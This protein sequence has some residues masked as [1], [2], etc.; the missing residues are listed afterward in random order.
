MKKYDT[1]II[2]CRIVYIYASNRNIIFHNIFSNLRD[3]MNNTVL[4]DKVK[5]ITNKRH[6]TKAWQKV[7]MVLSAITVFCTT[8]ALILPA[9]TMVDDDVALCGYVAHK[10]EESCYDEQGELICGLEEHEHDMGCLVTQGEKDKTVYFCAYDYEHTHTAACYSGDK[11]ICTMHE[12]THDDDCLKKT[13]MANATIKS[14]S[15]NDNAVAIVS[16]NLPVGAEAEI[17]VV[18][19]SRGELATY[20]GDKAAHVKQFAAY[21][22]KITLDGE[23]WQPDESVAVT[24][25][26]PDVNTDSGKVEAA[27]VDGNTNAISEVETEV[28]AKGDVQFEADGFSVYIIYTVDFEYNEAKY[29]IEGEGDILLSELFEKLKIENDVADV[30]SVDF[31]NDELL[32]IEDLGNDWRIVSLAPFDTEEKLT[33]TFKSGETLVIKVTDA[34]IA[35]NAGYWKKVTSIDDTNSSYIIV[36][37]DAAATDK[38]AFTR[39]NTGYSSTQVTINAVTGQTDYYTINTNVTDQM[40]FKFGK[41]IGTSGTTTVSTMN[42]NTP[43]YLTMTANNTA[44][45]T[46]STELTVKYNDTATSTYLANLWTFMNG[47][48]YYLNWANSAFTR[49]NSTTNYFS[50]RGMNL[51]KYYPG[52]TKDSGNFTVPVYTIPVDSNGRATGNATYQESLTVNNNNTSTTLANLFNNYDVDGTYY[53]AYY[54]TEYAAATSNVVSVTRSGNSNN[55]GANRRVRVTTSGGTTTDYNNDNNAIFLMY[56]TSGGGSTTSYWEPATEIKSGD[57]YMITYNGY[58]LGASSTA[59]GA[60]SAAAN[61]KRVDG[62]TDHYTTELGEAYQWTF[63]G[64]GN[65]YTIQNNETAT[66]YLKVNN[67]IVDDSRN[68]TVTYNTAGYWQFAGTGN[69]AGYYLNYTNNAFNRRNNNTNADTHMVVYH[70]VTSETPTTYETTKNADNSYTVNVYTVEINDSGNAVGTPVKRENPLSVTNN[71][72]ITPQNVFA[73]SGVTGTLIRADYKPAT[74]NAVSGSVTS[75]QRSNNNLVFTGSPNY[76]ASASN[77]NALYLYYT[78]DTG[79]DHTIRTNNNYTVDV[80][81]Q[82]V[83]ESGTAIGSPTLLTQKLTINNNTAITPESFFDTCGISGDYYSAVYKSANNVRSNNVT[84]IQRVNNELVF[85]GTP[86]YTVNTNAKSALYINYTVPTE[87]HTHRDENNYTVDVYAQKVEYSN[88]NPVHRR[89]RR[90]DQEQ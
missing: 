75:I 5:E 21:D 71:T 46:N 54:G 10:H 41:A 86:D 12:H 43:N 44:F 18:N 73:N 85:T 80:Y 62:T 6:R 60:T 48:N 76:T 67:N 65:T 45:G 8:Y 33:I 32:A 88:N 74:G 24:L 38:Y 9:I 66:R 72:A 63:T 27:H 87:I 77:Q 15:A 84:N 52:T 31:T 7:V 13:E 58:A 2:Y 34:Q 14:E 11:L 81:V 26:N 25:K 78:S 17:S 1:I 29:S 49:T 90:N 47:S 64:S 79:D 61:F 42:G 30:D 53:G 36:T 70:L 69:G 59:V 82:Q 22:I 83:N 57:T 28:N 16:G 4:A 89:S 50:T 20:L 39:N 56:T 40:Q 51:Y 37:N 35:A 19:M 68:V 23:E 55:N 3:I